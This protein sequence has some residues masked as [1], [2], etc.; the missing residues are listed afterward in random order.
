MTQL[1]RAARD[2]LASCGCLHALE[3]KREPLWAGSQVY[4][5]RWGGW[6][7]VRSTEPLGQSGGHITVQ[8]DHGNKPFDEL[9]NKIRTQSTV[10]LTVGRELE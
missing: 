10:T 1:A 4:G 3:G 9:E 2:I 6:Q 7:G 5:S 8:L